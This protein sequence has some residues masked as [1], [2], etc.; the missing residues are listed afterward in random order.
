MRGMAT[1]PQGNQELFSGQRQSTEGLLD[2]NVSI[3]MAHNKISYLECCGVLKCCY[4]MQY[5]ATF[6]SIFSSRE[7]LEETSTRHYLPF[8]STF[9]LL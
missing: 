4:L 8:T 7:L 6:L 3:V 1:L 5:F 2:V 9:R